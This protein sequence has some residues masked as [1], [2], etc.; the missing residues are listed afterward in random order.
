MGRF[1]PN[2]LCILVESVTA[3]SLCGK[4]MECY[5]IHLNDLSFENAMRWNKCHNFG[6]S[7][8]CL[9]STNNNNRRIA[10]AVYYFHRWKLSFIVCV[11]VTYNFFVPFNLFFPYYSQF[12]WLHSLVTHW[13]NSCGGKKNSKLCWIFWFDWR[14][15][16]QKRSRNGNGK[17]IFII[18]ACAAFNNLNSWV[19]FIYSKSGDFMLDIT[20]QL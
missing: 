15:I 10:I 6:V 9:K 11:F 4:Q 3:R 8:V 7:I 20:T 1:F 19:A 17:K 13:K 5:R 2:F 14:Q 18:F 16:I 12:T